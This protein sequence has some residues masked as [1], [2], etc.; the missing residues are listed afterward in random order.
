ME[1]QYQHFVSKF[2]LKNFTDNPNKTHTYKCEKGQWTGHNICNTG[3]E[4]LLYGPKDNSLEKF[5]CALENEIAAVNL[6]SYQDKKDGAYIKIF[7]LLMANRSPSKNGILTKKLE[8]FQK[9]IK[10]MGKEYSEEE[11]YSCLENRKR[12]LEGSLGSTDDPE[13]KKL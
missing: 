1:K 8:E 3:G 12:E 4:D 5:F 9:S 13:I 2:L 6:H 11:I 7:I 10:D